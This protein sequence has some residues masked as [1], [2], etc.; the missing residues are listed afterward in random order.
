MSLMWLLLCQHKCKKQNILQQDTP[1]GYSN[2]R[3]FFGLRLIWA[4]T[5]LR[6]SGGYSSVCFADTPGFGSHPLPM[7][8]ALFGSPDPYNQDEYSS[9]QERLEWVSHGSTL[10]LLRGLQRSRRLARGRSE[11]T[12]CRACCASSR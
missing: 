3:R 4:N 11:G 1:A 9:D 2:F 7:F 10:Q 5:L 12:Q 8:G 6:V